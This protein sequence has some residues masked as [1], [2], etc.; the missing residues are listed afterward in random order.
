MIKEN[1]FVFAKPQYIPLVDYVNHY[2]ELYIIV[3]ISIVYVIITIS[4]IWKIIRK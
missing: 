2:S 3:V 4:I 1:I